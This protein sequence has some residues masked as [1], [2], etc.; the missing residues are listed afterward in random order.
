MQQP[1]YGIVQFDATAFKAQFP[2]FATIADGLLQFCFDLATLLLDNSACSVVQDVTKRSPLLSL[3]TAHIA[4]IQLGENGQQPTGVV[5]RISQADQGSVSVKSEWASQFNAHA[6]YY[7]QTKYGALY[8]QATAQYRSG[9][10]FAPPI[11]NYGPPD[12]RRRGYLGGNDVYNGG[13]YSWGQ[14]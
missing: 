5:G 10:Y 3:L 6:A 7:L 12:P 8:W 14:W 2:S 1:V 11:C 4:A 13:F 9:M